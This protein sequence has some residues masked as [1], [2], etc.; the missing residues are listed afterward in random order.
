MI[1]WEF[2]NKYTVVHDVE[3]FSHLVLH[4]MTEICWKYSYIQYL[5]A[6]GLELIIK[7][8]ERDY[9]S[10]TKIVAKLGWDSTNWII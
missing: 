10:L 1:L 9:V 6:L 2:E 7:K 3:N 4:W 5:H 8:N